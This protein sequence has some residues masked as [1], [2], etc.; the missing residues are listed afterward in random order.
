MFFYWSSGQQIKYVCST[1]TSDVVGKRKNLQYLVSYLRLRLR[2][3]G[4]ER[5]RV[6][7]EGG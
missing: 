4:L 3:G 5:G 6:F 1:E 2:G 7:W